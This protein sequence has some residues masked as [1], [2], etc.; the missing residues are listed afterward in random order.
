MAFF[1]T[2]SL[3]GSGGRKSRDDL[4]EVLRT[5][6]KSMAPLTVHGPDG[7]TLGLSP[8]LFRQLSTVRQWWTKIAGRSCGRFANR[9]EVH[10]V[11]TIKGPVAT[12]LG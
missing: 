4:A 1:S 3:C 12:T 7:A 10:S 2:Q 6:G 5:F 11:H 8:G 9:W